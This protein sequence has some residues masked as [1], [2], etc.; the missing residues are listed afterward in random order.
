MKICP[1]CN[2]L[3]GENRTECWKCGAILGPVDK[4]KKVCLRCGL[5]YPQKAEICDKCGGR[6][7]V[8]DGSTNYKFSRNDS[9]GCWLYI[10]AILFPLIGI[11]LGCVYL[12][13]REDELGKS[14]IITSV[15]VIVIFALLSLLF[16]SCASASLLNTKIY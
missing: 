6:L 3:N 2:E 10:I 12:A 8:Y 11:I 14:L 5:I 4:Y 15:V 1:K 7:S 16:V 9:S 13:R